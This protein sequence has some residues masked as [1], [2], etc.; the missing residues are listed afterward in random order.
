[1]IFIGKEVYAPSDI[2]TMTSPKLPQVMS[3]FSPPV[4]INTKINHPI[5]VQK[6]N[7][8]V[9]LEKDESD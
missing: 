2:P 7:V 9:G 5:Q 3:T 1:M 8:L 6:P 4:E